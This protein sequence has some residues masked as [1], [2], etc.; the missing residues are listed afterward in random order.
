MSLE[1][2][3]LRAVFFM[4]ADMCF[5]DH[6][7]QNENEGCY[8]QA[9]VLICYISNSTQLSVL[10]FCA[11]GLPTPHAIFGHRL[12]KNDLL[13]SPSVFPGDVADFPPFA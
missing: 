5:H 3:K 4:G 9:H 7:A 6:D 13:I 11:M 1:T 8:Q 2:L 12:F 10:P